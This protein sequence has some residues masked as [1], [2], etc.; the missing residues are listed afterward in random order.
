MIAGFAIQFAARVFWHQEMKSRLR[1]EQD[2]A[3]LALHRTLLE[4][5]EYNEYHALWCPQLGLLKK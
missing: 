4:N 2:H 1:M 5:H 3:L